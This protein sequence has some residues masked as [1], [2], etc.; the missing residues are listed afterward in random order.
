MERSDLYRGVGKSTVQIADPSEIG[1]TAS[2][3]YSMIESQKLVTKVFDSSALMIDPLEVAALLGYP[4]GKQVPPKVLGILPELQARAVELFQPM[5]QYAIFPIRSIDQEEQTVTLESMHVFHGEGVVETLRYST[6][7]AI[8]LV[9]LGHP[10]IEE[11]ERLNRVDV[12]KGFFLDVIS[13]VAVENLA[14]QVHLEIAHLILGQGLY[15]G[16]R[17][18]P[19]FCDWDLTQQ[20][21]MFSLLDSSVLSVQLTDHCMMIPRKSVSA[22][23]GA[24]RERVEM[25]I[26]PCG[27]CKRTDCMARR[28][29]YMNILYQSEESHEPL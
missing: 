18:S 11:I 6:Q 1:R 19:G 4:D 9:T 28:E 29:D 20:R 15:V 12:S 10:I 26:S 17:Y 3:S 23:F 8:F 5:Y 13:S 2:T 24:G 22:I 14:E 7:A 27:Y 21:V 16:H 25:V